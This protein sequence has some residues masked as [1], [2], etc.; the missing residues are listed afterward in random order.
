MGR[1]AEAKAAEDGQ[2]G[3][4]PF[5]SRFLL[6]SVASLVVVAVL[7]WAPTARMTET[8]PALAIVPALL[9][10]W[11]ASLTGTIPIFLARGK[12]PLEAMPSQFGAMAVRLVTI[13][14]LGASLAL[15]GWVETKPFLIWLVIGHIA[16]LV[17]DT[18]LARSVVLAASRRETGKALEER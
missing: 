7:G 15:G 4:G 10:A 14:L 13:L 1:A 5:Y 2:L 12:S 3:T 11:A 8:N 18:Q 9:V 6:Q 16:L 17:T